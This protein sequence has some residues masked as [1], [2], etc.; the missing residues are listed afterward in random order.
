[1]TTRRHRLAEF[2]DIC[3]DLREMIDD[4]KEW[5]HNG[6]KPDCKEDPCRSDPLFHRIVRLNW[7][8]A[9]KKVECLDEGVLDK[10]LEQIKKFWKL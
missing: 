4:R 3:E 2:F 6:H 9:A 7:A 1:M 5:H 10:E 8:L